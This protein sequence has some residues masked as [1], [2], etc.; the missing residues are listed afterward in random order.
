M[1]MI[2][3]GTVS[4]RVRQGARK[5]ARKMAEYGRKWDRRGG[6]E[7]PDDNSD[8]DSEDDEG[9]Q[10]GEEG[11]DEEGQ[12][13]EEGD[14]EKEG[15][16]GTQTGDGDDEKPKDGKKGKKKG[17][18]DKE[19]EEPKT[20]EDWMKDAKEN[21]DFEFVPHRSFHTIYVRTD[22]KR[23][24]FAV[25]EEKMGALFFTQLTSQGAE[26]GLPTNFDTTPKAV[27]LQFAFA[28]NGTDVMLVEGPQEISKSETHLASSMYGEDGT[29]MKGFNMVMAPVLHDEANHI[30]L[31]DM[32]AW[33]ASFAQYFGLSPDRGHDDHVAA[34]RGYGPMPPPGAPLLASVSAFPQ[35]FL[36][37]MIAQSPSRNPLKGGRHRAEGQ[38]QPTA[39]GYH[40]GWCGCCS[41]IMC[42][43]AFNPGESLEAVAAADP[44]QFLEP[45]AAFGSTPPGKTA[46]FTVAFSL[47][48]AT[49]MVSRR[50][51]P[52]AQH[53]STQH[54]MI[55]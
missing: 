6:D 52:E 25:E 51:T 15:D 3:I 20:V 13:G 21:R 54:H 42:A 26:G 48:P 49:P 11:D 27:G 18:E 33:I 10:G 34:G 1:R 35:N 29:L 36:F 8:S 40:A 2:Q 5:M 50:D 14:E 12:E 38:E 37:K 32:T 43:Q 4:V 9:E 39:K 28:P 41:A 44:R 19:D 31:L 55:A 45:P 46:H 30:L 24:L 53:S 22:L 23:I 16:K 17:K 7:D 47:L